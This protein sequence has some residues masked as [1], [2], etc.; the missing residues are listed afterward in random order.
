MLNSLGTFK[1]GKLFILSAPSG[2]GKTTLVR[3]LVKEFP[4]V[5]GNISYTSR[6]PR[7]EEK[8]GVDYHFISREEFERMLKKGAFLEYATV[9]GEFYGTEKKKVEK[10]LESGKHVFLVI[11]TQGALQIREKMEAVSIFVF[12]PSI[13][14][15]CARLQGRG[16]ETPE[17]IEKRISWAKNEMKVGL[18]SYNY[19]II[20]EDIDVAYD[21]LR[22]IV[23][24][25]SHRI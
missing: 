15:L 4:Q 6:A 9:Y 23:I 22:S 17:Q 14:V 13:E 21:V 1:K 18:E 3:R 8:E 25:E 10:L 11:E 16:T 5:I 19:Q 7:G 12:P 20:N 2:T 24:A